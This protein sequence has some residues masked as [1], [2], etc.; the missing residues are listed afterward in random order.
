MASEYLNWKFRDVKPDPR[1]APLTPQEKWNNWWHYHKWQVA[2]GAAVCLMAA[3][4]A[5]NA[6]GVG[7]VRPDY[8]IAYVGQ[9]PLP[10]QTAAAVEQA[11]EALGTDANGDGRTVVQLHQ[12][13]LVDDGGENAEYAYANQVTLMGDL[14]DADSYFFLLENGETFQA[15]DAVL[16]D[17][18]GALAQAGETPL[19][20]RWSD[21]PALAGQDLGSYTQTLLGQEISG[22]SQ[23]LLS[24][25]TL[26]RRGFWE[27][28][29]C[30]HQD[31][32]DD[33]WNTLT[34]GADPA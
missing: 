31:A 15:D 19:T 30:D 26:A 2:A 34:K 24:S 28:R 10:D 11:F 4:L 6:L 13:L 7:K 5:C 27:D 32:C 18:S 17:A 1:P 14:E 25:L 16:A 20:L 12:Y 21:C 22:S 23:E 3:D 8:Q 33:L 9:S 29:T